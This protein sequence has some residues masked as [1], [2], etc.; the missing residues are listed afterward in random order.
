MEQ[1]IKILK[2]SKEKLSR[3]Y[4]QIDEG[5]L[6]PPQLK[7][8]RDLKALGNDSVKRRTYMVIEE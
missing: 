8:L 2:D 1:S 4:K 7:E 6:E 3:L 5:P